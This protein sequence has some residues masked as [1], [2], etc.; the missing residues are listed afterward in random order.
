MFKA[1]IISQPLSL[2]EADSIRQ[3]LKFYKR[4]M[5]QYPNKDNIRINKV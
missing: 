3:C 4:Y 1:L 5:K 2:D